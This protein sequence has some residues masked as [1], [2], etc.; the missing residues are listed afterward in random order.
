MIFGDFYRCNFI[1]TGFSSKSFAGKNEVI[2]LNRKARA[3]TV[4]TA[5]ADIYIEL[6]LLRAWTFATLATY[7]I[8]AIPRS[9]TLDSLL[10][11]RKHSPQSTLATN[12]IWTSSPV[13]YA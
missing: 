6:A 8:R 4:L 7:S 13:G 11:C 12:S 10:P 9:A 5:Y 2:A 1:K 3:V